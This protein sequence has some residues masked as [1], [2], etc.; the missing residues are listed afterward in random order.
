MTVFIGDRRGGLTPAQRAEVGAL[1]G[2][3]RAEATGGIVIEVPVGGSERARGD[4]RG[5]A[6]SARSSARPACRACDRDAAAITAQDPVRLGDHPHQLSEDGGRDRARAG[7]GRTTSAR[8]T[9]RC[10]GATSRT[11]ITAARRQRN[12]AAQV[13]NPADLVQPRGE[14]PALAAR[15]STV[16]DKYRKGE[17]TATSLSGCQ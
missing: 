3:W 2:G 9:T 10:T 4:Q 1:A 8:P 5:R 6:R 17:G 16:I 14:T 11:G 15:R 12:L 13:D 7:C